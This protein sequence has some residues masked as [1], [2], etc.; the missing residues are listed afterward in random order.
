MPVMDGFETIKAV[1]Q[2]PRWKH[3]P[4]LALTADTFDTTNEKVHQA[5]MNGFIP[6]P[7]QQD[8]I[9]TK[10]KKAISV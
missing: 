5:G 10:I 4:V 7:F 6:K 2:D 8:D 1:R 3:L 9:Y